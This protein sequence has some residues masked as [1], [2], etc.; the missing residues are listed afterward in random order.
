MAEAPAEVIEL[1]EKRAQARAE[2]DFATADSLRD[3]IH[4]LG[5]EVVDSAQGFSLDPLVA[6]VRRIHPANVE[7]VLA[8]PARAEFSVQWVVQGWP[9]DALR[10]MRSFRAHQ[11]SHS[12]QFVV[13]DAVGSHPSYYPQ[14]AEEVW[15]EDDFGWGADRNAGLR[16]AAGDI[17][18]VVDG[19]VEVTGDVFGPI[20]EALG[21]PNVGVVGP[22]G[23]VTDDLREFRESEGPDV[24]A[25]EGYLMAF[26]RGMLDELEGFDEKFRFYRSADIEFSFRVKEAG[27]RAVV[28]PLPVR[29]HEHR[30]WT[31]TPEAERDKLS[32]RNFY[33][34]LERFRDRTDLLVAG[35]GPS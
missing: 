28:V 24:D 21:D 22:F 20:A 34:F 27:Y 29:R 13:V 31:N 23:I 10:G 18:V 7:S 14:V 32:K 4:E 11:G 5:W 6:E 17:V 1:A 8:M 19:S 2:R 25:I 12:V 33:R 30:M 3:R 9:E 15:L 16:R 26:R 35:K